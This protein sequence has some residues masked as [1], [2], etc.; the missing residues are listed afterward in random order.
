MYAKFTLLI[1][2]F[3]GFAQCKKN[4]KKESIR[5]DS[6]YSNAKK[7]PEDTQSF[8]RL[9]GRWNSVNN[10]FI[11]T[12]EFCN[13]SSAIIHSIGDTIFRYKFVVG[14]DKI[15]F[16]DILAHEDASCYRFVS[17]DSLWVESLP[18]KGGN[19]YFLRKH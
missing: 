3:L 12:I 17:Q 13:D 10:K 2:F 18:N 4:E 16:L 15:F 5:Q 8:D 6:F 19:L 14:C 9:I 1:V 7:C 11:P